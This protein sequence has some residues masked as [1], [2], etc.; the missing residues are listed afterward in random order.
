MW[1]QWNILATLATVE[2]GLSVQDLPALKSEF[3]AILC[4]I[5]TCLKQFK[6]QRLRVYSSIMNLAQGSGVHSKYQKEKR[7]GGEGRRGGGSGRRGGRG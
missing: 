5:Q 7:W 4:N 2:E 1:A 6:N 3:K